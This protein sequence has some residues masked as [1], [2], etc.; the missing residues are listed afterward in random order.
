ME[1]HFN[2]HADPQE[3]EILYSAV[4]HA[5]LRQHEAFVTVLAAGHMKTFNALCKRL[6][7]VVVKVVDCV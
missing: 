3:H 1:F 7:A 2:T 6:I 5:S 4:H